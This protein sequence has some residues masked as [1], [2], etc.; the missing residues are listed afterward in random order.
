M[1]GGPGQGRRSGFTPARTSD[2]PWDARRPG[3]GP[4]VR[5]HTG[6]RFARGHPSGPGSRRTVEAPACRH[7]ALSLVAGHAGRGT[8]RDRVLFGTSTWVCPGPTGPPADEP[9]ALPPPA[10]VVTAR[11]SGNAAALVAR[12]AG[13][14]GA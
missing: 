1:R 5:L 13:T 12:A 10:D 7:R 4:P 6:H 2:A 9:G 14:R 11:L 8:A 3:A